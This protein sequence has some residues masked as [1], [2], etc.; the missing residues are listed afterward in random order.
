MTSGGVLR[1]SPR[2]SARRSHRLGLSP[3]LEAPAPG[4][5]AGYRVG[6]RRGLARVPLA[7]R[8]ALL[9]AGAGL[10]AE[11]DAEERHEPPA[12]QADGEQAGLPRGVV[13]EL[14]H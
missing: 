8:E 9:P 4:E 11:I 10:D 1:R 5:Q 3:A 7:L 13:A 14:A 12:E 6:A 2:S